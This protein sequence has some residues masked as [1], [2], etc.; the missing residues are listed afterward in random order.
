MEE[1]REARGPGKGAFDDPAMRE[2]HEDVSGLGELEHFKADSLFG[3][4][5]GASFGGVTLFNISNFDHFVDRHLAFE[6]STP[7]WALS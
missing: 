2:K 4:L 3:S 1:A 7:T 6:A 5:S